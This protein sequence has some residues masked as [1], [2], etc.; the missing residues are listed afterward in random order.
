[1]STSLPMF[2]MKASF[3]S[4]SVMQD[5][6]HAPDARNQAD[7]PPFDDYLSKQPT[8]SAPSG[9]TTS[10]AETSPKTGAR[11]HAEPE[12]QAQEK[13]GNE[14]SERTAAKGHRRKAKAA[15]SMPR[16]PGD[17]AGASRVSLQAAQ[18]DN[19]EEIEALTVSL[20][21]EADGPEPSLK[22]DAI[23]PEGDGEDAKDAGPDGIKPKAEAADE[24]GALPREAADT[25]VQQVSF[26][27]LNGASRQP[28]AMPVR[29][30]FSSETGRPLRSFTDKAV[31]VDADFDAVSSM[32]DKHISGAPKGDNRSALHPD[33][34]LA[35]VDEG[36]G[37]RLEAP[38]GNGRLAD[39]MRDVKLQVEDAGQ[40]R[41]FAPP[42]ALDAAAVATVAV[43]D[44]GAIEANAGR[45]RDAV[46]QG[47]SDLTGAHGQ[48]GHAVTVNRHLHIQLKP[49]HLGTVSARLTLQQ[50]V[51]EIRIT[52]PDSAWAE[53]VRRDAE[54]LARR[55][56]TREGHAGGMRQVQVHIGVDPALAVV[57]RQ[58][59]QMPGPGQSPSHH[60]GGQAGAGQGQG[61]FSGQ[62][63]DERSRAGSS[64]GHGDLGRGDEGSATQTE[65]DPRAVY[66]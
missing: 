18:M 32:P 25:P 28:G 66:L 9:S 16:R 60:P 23:R 12:A 29:T 6:A 24:K 51:L 41:H 34:F 48:T 33:A 47:L 59:A 50:G 5:Q 49:E 22:P 62:G 58:D 1:M 10:A 31:P 63:Q 27:F 2:S 21:K 30:P 57:S 35:G 53:R 15:S 56:I 36:R 43:D 61:A 14:I 55:I 26:G 13:Q 20:M 39:V 46:L 52:L 4:A 65:R 45:I 17:G 40:S 64:S 38:A 11:A 7:A 42:R 3:R 37:R 54:D 44:A 19:P 8:G